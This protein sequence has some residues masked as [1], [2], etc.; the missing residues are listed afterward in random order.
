MG[1]A[2]DFREV[3]RRGRRAAA[4]TLVL[5][6]LAADEVAGAAGFAEP[7]APIVGL[8]V[9]RAVGGSVVRNR[10]KRRL[11]HQ[12]R[13]RLGDVP[14]GSRLV[15]RA[16]PAAAGASSAQLADDLD[17]SLRR[18]LDSYEPRGRGR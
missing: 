12:L 2:S 14:T 13:D 5:H 8:A 11:R 18:C 7:P 9:S 1:D 10:V 17:R 15:V 3:T 4:R 6:V 16:L